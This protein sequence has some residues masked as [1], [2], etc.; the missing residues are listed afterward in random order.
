MEME[1]KFWKYSFSLKHVT[2]F[3]S[4]ILDMLSIAS[5]FQCGIF[6]LFLSSFLTYGISAQSSFEADVRHCVDKWRLYVDIFRTLYIFYRLTG[7]YASSLLAS[8][9]TNSSDAVNRQL[10][11]FKIRFTRCESFPHLVVFAK[12]VT[13]ATALATAI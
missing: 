5:F 11:C 12:F 7:N 13:I 9:Q 1:L 2:Y 6:P 3:N 4:A 10:L 8:H